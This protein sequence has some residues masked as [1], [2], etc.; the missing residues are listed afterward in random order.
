VL[1]YVAV[2]I[3]VCKAEAAYAYFFA[4]FC[5]VFFWQCSAVC[6]IALRSM[7][8]SVLQYVVV[9]CSMLQY[10]AVNCSI[11][12]C[13]VVCVAV[14][15]AK[16]YYTSFFCSVLQCVLQSVVQYGMRCVAISCS[17]LQYVAVCCSM[18]QCVAV[19]CGACCR[20]QY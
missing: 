7:L 6:C 1:Q 17:V 3:A 13:V 5:S 9:W 10:V 12:Q 20:V 14:C 4:V 18:L 11:L 2:R 16:A 8:H 15:N 19:C